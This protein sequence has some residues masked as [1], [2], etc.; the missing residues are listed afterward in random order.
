M[1]QVYVRSTSQWPGWRLC[2]ACTVLC[3]GHNSLSEDASDSHCKRT[4]SLASSAVLTRIVIVLNYRYRCKFVS[5]FLLL[6]I[7]VLHLADVIINYLFSSCIV[8]QFSS[9]SRSFL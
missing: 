7:S 8:A 2:A 6:L 4:Y 3:T 5:D 9:E 1:L